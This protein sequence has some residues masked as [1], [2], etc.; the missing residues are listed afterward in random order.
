MSELEIKIKESIIRAVKEKNEVAKDVL[1]TVLGQM[2]LDASSKE[3]SEDDRLNVIRKQ[4][5]SN[6]L[7]IEQM[8]NVDKSEWKTDWEDNNKKLAF[9]IGLLSMFL[10]QV[11]SEIDT[12]DLIVKTGLDLK[13]AKND[14]QAIGMAMK[15]LKSSGAQVDASVVR[16]IVEELRK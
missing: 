1:R 3:L 14:G 9:E 11:L 10:P 5:K 12:K 16:K 4:I 7:S 15:A 6:Q 13:S 8:S 2:Q